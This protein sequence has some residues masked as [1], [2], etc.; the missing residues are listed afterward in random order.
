MPSS[1][2]GVMGE[3][4]LRS[5]REGERE[6]GE[7][8]GEDWAEAISRYQSRQEMFSRRRPSFRDS[9]HFVN[10]LFEGVH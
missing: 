1:D 10:T 3:G 5:E 8:A 4:L 2:M 7:E 9:L 6:P